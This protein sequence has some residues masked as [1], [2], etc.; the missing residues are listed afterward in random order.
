MTPRIP[1]LALSSPNLAKLLARLLRWGTIFSGQAPNWIC[2]NSS[3]R[4]LCHI[5][6]TSASW[7]ALHEGGREGEKEDRLT[8]GKKVFRWVLQLVSGI[9]TWYQ[10]VLWYLVYT[11]VCVVDLYT[12]VWG[13]PCVAKLLRHSWSPVCFDAD[14]AWLCLTSHPS[15]LL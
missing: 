12:V 4:A 14:G 13:L 10:L 9:C 1:S 15:W 6:N 3:E 11:Y 8:E 2:R 5:R 7:L